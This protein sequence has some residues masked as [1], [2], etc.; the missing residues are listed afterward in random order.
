VKFRQAAQKSLLRIRV[1]QTPTRYEV[2]GIR[3]D[4][5]R[6]GRE[7]VLG[8][9]LGALFL[10]ER[11]AEP[12]EDDEPS[13]AVPPTKYSDEHADELRLPDLARNIPS[14]SRRR[15]IAADQLAPRRRGLVSGFRR[16]SRDQPK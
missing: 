13:P 15:A 14:T 12:V 3:L 2:D 1:V 8:N 7:Y 10:A 11:W 5:F 16:T 6:P 9:N 4:Q